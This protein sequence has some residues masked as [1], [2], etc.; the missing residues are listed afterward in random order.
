[1]SSE[2]DENSPLLA[3][4]LGQHVNITHEHPVFLRVAHSPWAFFGQKS[5]LASRT[6]LALYT[7]TVWIY[8]LVHDIEKNKVQAKMF[9]FEADVISFTL[10]VIY[11]WIS[12]VSRRQTCYV[13]LVAT[14][15]TRL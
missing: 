2:S 1:M 10:Q 13:A 11:Y 9:A 14:S 8:K 12:T 4:P 5:L 3:E 7:T 15:R 6:L